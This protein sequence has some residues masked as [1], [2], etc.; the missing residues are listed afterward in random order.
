MGH[1][2]VVRP[3]R[4]HTSNAY[5]MV[6][7]AKSTVNAIKK[8]VREAKHMA[9]RCKTKGP[10]FTKTQ[11]KR[12]TKVATG[13]QGEGT[14]SVSKVIVL[15]KA[16]KKLRLLKALSNPVLH[17]QITGLSKECQ[18]GLCDYLEFGTV[19]NLWI[20]DRIDEA[21][22]QATTGAVPTGAVNTQAFL[23]SLQ[24]RHTI[25]NLANTPIKLISYAFVPKIDASYTPV[26]YAQSGSSTQGAGNNLATGAGVYFPD[27]N[28]KT[29]S[30]VKYGWTQKWRTVQFMKPGE[31]IIQ[32]TRVHMNL[33][34]TDIQS[35]A[36]TELVYKYLRGQTPYFV[37][38]IQG[39]AVVEILETDV[40]TLGAAKI[41][42]IEQ[43]SSS[44]TPYP[45]TM[46]ALRRFDT[47]NGLFHV[48]A[49]STEIMNVD[50]SKAEQG[51]TA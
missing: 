22:L 20:Q 32:N 44:C 43:L 42:V 19:T 33:L 29:F 17:R 39:A 34:K 1:H 14:A 38:Q 23:Q 25:T 9:N 8:Q 5:N 26:E 36:Q 18:T 45:Y 2:S 13:L 15:H 30:T 6:T 40:P 47:V 10:S 7:R 27:Q 51:D 28:F 16:P 3:G 37:F 50:V 49:A 35:S 46:T 21:I 24:Y 48:D 4:N 12:K 11:T 41:G 31:T